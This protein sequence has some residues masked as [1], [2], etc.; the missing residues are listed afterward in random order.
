[1][2]VE[3]SYDEL[4]RNLDAPGIGGATEARQALGDNNIKLVEGDA[5]YAKEQAQKAKGGPRARTAPSPAEA[6]CSEC[7]LR[8]PGS[9]P[10]PSLRRRLSRRGT[11]GSTA[12]ATPPKEKQEIDSRAKRRSGVRADW[13]LGSGGMA[14]THHMPV[15]ALAP[16]ALMLLR[17]SASPARGREFNRDSD[18]AKAEA[19]EA[20]E[21]LDEEIGTRR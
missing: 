10:S 7:R 19:E 4:K 13:V 8:S 9:A 5:A 6:S 11:N 18:A 17:R 1:M 21:N 12:T 15:L 3:G 16:C 14:W 2:A 20:E